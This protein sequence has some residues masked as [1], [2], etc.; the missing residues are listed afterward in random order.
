MEDGYQ[1][2]YGFCYRRLLVVTKQEKICSFEPMIP[3][4]Q[5]TRCYDSKDIKKHQLNVQILTRK[6]LKIITNLPSLFLPAVL[7]ANF[8]F[9]C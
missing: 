8:I 1:I 5:T 6:Y 9:R 4:D 2:F 7:Q 3:L